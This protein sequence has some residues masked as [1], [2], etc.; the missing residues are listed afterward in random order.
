[1]VVKNNPGK[2]S[3]GSESIKKMKQFTLFLILVFIH[4]VFVIFIKKLLIF[5]FLRF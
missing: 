3:F 1:M 4:L 5:I 2:R